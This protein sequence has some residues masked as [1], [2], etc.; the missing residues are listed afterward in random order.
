MVSLAE[1]IDK[2]LRMVPSFYKKF[3]I[4][5]DEI[6]PYDYDKFLINNSLQVCDESYRK[7][8]DFTDIIL[9]TLPLNMQYTYQDYQKYVYNI[10]ERLGDSLDYTE[11]IKNFKTNSISRTS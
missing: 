6:D 9:N 3:D 8:V 2:Q 11:L 1:Y 5:V 7:F 4:I 10:K